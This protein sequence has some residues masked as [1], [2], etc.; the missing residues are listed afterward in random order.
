M[1]HRPNP[2]PRF[3]NPQYANSSLASGQSASSTLQNAPVSGTNAANAAANAAN[4]SRRDLNTVAPRHHGHSFS[5]ATPPSIANQDGS[6]PN[7]SERTG[8]ASQRTLPPPRFQR[9]QRPPRVQNILAGPDNM[10]R[11]LGTLTFGPATNW[12]VGTQ[13]VVSLPM[14]AVNAASSAL[15]SSP[16]LASLP[17]TAIDDLPSGFPTSAFPRINL[18]ST[19]TTDSSPPG[20]SSVS[21]GSASLPNPPTLLVSLIL[22]S[23][24]YEQIQMLAAHTSLSASSNSF[25]SHHAKTRPRLRAPRLFWRHTLP[26]HSGRSM[27]PT[28]SLG[29][30]W[31]NPVPPHPPHHL[32]A[33]TPA[34]APSSL[35]LFLVQSPQQR[36]TL[37]LPLP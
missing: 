17:P 20:L 4:N 13:A 11:S 26:L 15:G 24:P 29:I 12:G 36:S 7:R 10:D 6:I 30:P 23:S 32:T 1:P 19:T 18:E 8:G 9:K 2:I 34:P 37:S 21:L 27:A 16:S 14:A 3:N 35:F 28:T 5:A 31:E 33:P 22:Q 25:A